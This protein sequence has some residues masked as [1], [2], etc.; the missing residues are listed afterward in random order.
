MKKYNKN[1]ITIITCLVAAILIAALISLLICTSISLIMGSGLVLL[2]SVDTVANDK[3][4]EYIESIENQENSNNF[5]HMLTGE[6]IRFNDLT[7]ADSA[8]TFGTVLPVVI[9]A[10]LGGC[11]SLALTAI[12]FHTMHR[13][14]A[15][16]QTG[17]PFQSANVRRIER[18]GWLAI[19]SPIVGWALTLLCKFI[20]GDT[21]VEPSLDITGLAMGL[22]VLI[23]S[24]FFAYGVSLQNDVDGLV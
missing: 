1:I 6:P 22:M 21:M 12:M 3:A 9:T 16:A 11:I 13:V 23:L 24:R 14:L 19:I 4:L 7:I 17:S 5:F 10:L 20:L 18:I 8:E 2:F 15:S